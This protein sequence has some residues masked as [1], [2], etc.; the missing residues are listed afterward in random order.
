M[1]GFR[2]S[3]ANL[4][5]VILGTAIGCAIVKYAFLEPSLGAVFHLTLGVLFL[6][7]LGIAYLG[8]VGAFYSGFASLGFGH[9]LW[10]TTWPPT[11]CQLAL[12]RGIQAFDRQYYLWATIEISRQPSTAG[13]RES[14]RTRWQPRSAPANMNK[15]FS[16]H[17]NS[18]SEDALIESVLAS[19][20]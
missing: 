5:D 10:F 2:Y 6:A 11:W 13:W 8:E 16:G 14:A 15:F 7:V 12:E 3:L 4:R 9:V 20:G 17:W 18:L 19:V 1:N